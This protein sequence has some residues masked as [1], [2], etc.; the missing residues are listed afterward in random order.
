MHKM[1]REPGQGELVLLL[2]PLRKTENAGGKRAHLGG[3]F[4]GPEKVVS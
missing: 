1:V 4:R 3:G 2:L